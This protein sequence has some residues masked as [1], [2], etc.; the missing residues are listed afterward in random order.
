MGR[1]VR[2]EGMVRQ[3]FFIQGF[4]VGRSFLS[5]KPATN[6]PNKIGIS[7]LIAEGILPHHPD[8]GKFREST[9]GWLWQ[10]RHGFHK[11]SVS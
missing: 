6:K 11:L 10:R 9:V 8:S 2:I 5:S 4:P 1:K 7:V 3:F